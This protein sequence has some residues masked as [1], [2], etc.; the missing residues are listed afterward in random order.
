MSQLK[1]VDDSSYLTAKLQG[2]GLVSA[3]LV[4]GF[5]LTGAHMFGKSISCYGNVDID[6]VVD[7]C[8]AQALFTIQDMGSG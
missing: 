4:I 3:F 2:Y 8:L 1:S 7:W 5:L 6:G